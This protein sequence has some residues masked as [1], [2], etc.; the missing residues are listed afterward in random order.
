MLALVICLSL[1]A[2]GGEASNSGQNETAET[3]ATETTETPATE[4]A[5]GTE[6]AI[7]EAFETD[8]VKCVVTEVRWV[9]LEDVTSHPAAREVLETDGQPFTALELSEMF[10]GY[11]FYG[12]S[13]L[14]SK[15]KNYPY[16]CV[17][18]TLQN[19]GKEIIEPSLGSNVWDFSPYGTIDILYDDGYIFESEEGF[20]TTLEVLGEAF[21]E[22]RVFEVPSQVS[23]NKD[24]ALKVKITLPNS[25][26]ETEEFIVSVR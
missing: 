12:I 3:P 9:T 25:S 24:K 26:G 19:V 4:T 15:G 23:E 13:G 2:C 21:L 16:L 5:D 6:Y 10:P 11:S 7:G 18:F 22:G 17:T 14:S 20:T 8:S 1:V